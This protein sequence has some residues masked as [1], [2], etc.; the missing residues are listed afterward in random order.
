MRIATIRKDEKMPQVTDD[1]ALEIQVNVE[2]AA[3]GSGPAVSTPVPANERQVGGT[4]YRSEIQHWDYVVANDIPYLE[5]QVIKYLT[6]WRK[7]NGLE[8]V[9]KAQ[10]YLQKLI[11]V[12]EAKA[13][14]KGAS[15]E[16]K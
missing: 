2:R 10:H 11:E 3:A 1:E 15:D 6:R 8:D 5:A 13:N 9:Y 14:E 4:H 7:K 12:E 16:R